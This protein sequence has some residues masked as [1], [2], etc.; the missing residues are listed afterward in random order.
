VVDLVVPGFLID[1]ILDIDA[2]LQRSGRMPYRSGITGLA[3]RGDISRLDAPGVSF[4]SGRT[5]TWAAAEVIVNTPIK[6]VRSI[7]G[8]ACID[9]YRVPVKFRKTVSHVPKMR[10]IRSSLGLSSRL[11]TKGR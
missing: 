5:D 7:T 10:N 1:P 6:T 8:I 9:V 4:G 2:M 3:Y 11:G